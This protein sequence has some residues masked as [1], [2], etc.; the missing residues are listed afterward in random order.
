MAWFP[1]FF[2]RALPFSHRHIHPVSKGLPLIKH[3][4]IFF[5]QSPSR[6]RI[7][8]IRVSSLTNRMGSCKI[9]LTFGP[10]DTRKLCLAFVG[11][12]VA[13]GSTD[14]QRL[15]TITCLLA[16][17]PRY[18]PIPPVR[19][20][21]V[22]YN[23]LRFC[24]LRRFTYTNV[25]TFALCMSPCLPHP[26]SDPHETYKNTRKTALHCTK[27]SHIETFLFYSLCLVFS[28]ACPPTSRVCLLCIVIYGRSELFHF[29]FLSVLK[30]LCPFD[31][32]TSP[33]IPF[34][35]APL[36]TTHYR[37]CYLQPA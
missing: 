5:F 18:H 14:K 30:P 6:H 16:P 15:R 26:H 27:P 37:P 36:A 20:I 35:S 9:A 13:T 32:L 8:Y 25:F 12:V 10:H 7:V 23:S 31:S 24:I 22:V 19:E 28:V 1:S 29:T 3:R 11:T 4:Q 21:L 33:P 34:V 2:S 17:P